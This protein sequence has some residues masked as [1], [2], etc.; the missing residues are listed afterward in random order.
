MMGR[1]AV[2]DAEE[3]DAVLALAATTVALN[4]R[5]TEKTAPKHDGGTFECLFV[6]GLGIC[7]A[8]SN[9]MSNRT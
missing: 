3:I 6:G 4:V 5:V 2:A 8:A 7:V 1:V 9:D